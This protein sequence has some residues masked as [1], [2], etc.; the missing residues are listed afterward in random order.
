MN[1]TKTIEFCA[2][3]RVP[4]HTVD[5]RPGKCA[6]PHGHA[7]RVEVTVDGAIP[8]DGMILDFG[9][10][11]QVLTEQI[12]G[13]FD[14]GMLVWQGDKEL[15]GAL[16]GHGWKVCELEAPPTSENLALEVVRRVGP[17][18]AALG[19]RLTRVCVW[20]TPTSCATWDQR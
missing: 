12:H 19:V 10:V 6:S 18:L 7:Y 20:E 8:A 16:S 13:P 3:H 1:I 4:G 15:L 14:H 11:K 5:G 17:A 9:V 2:G